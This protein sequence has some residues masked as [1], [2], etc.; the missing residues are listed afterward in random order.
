M[1]KYSSLINWKK[2]EILRQKITSINKKITNKS[3]GIL[4]IYI[5]KNIQNNTFKLN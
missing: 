3:L 4:K 2:K 1:G 5:E